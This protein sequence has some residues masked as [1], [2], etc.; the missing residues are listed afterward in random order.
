MSGES[1]VIRMKGMMMQD[2]AKILIVDDEKV[3]LKNLEH[4]MKK[5]GYGVVGTESGPNA[6]KLLE[7]QP[8][9]VVLTDLKMEKVDGMQ[10][11]KKCRDLYPDA[12]VIMITGYVTLESA[13]QTIK[14]GAFYYVVKPFKL[15]EVRKV[16]KEAVEKVRLKKGNIKSKL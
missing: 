12:E 9:D 2:N 3:A 1:V 8:F 15:D 14:H 7:E 11:L 10:I 4:I 5:E 13:V 16:V 6:L